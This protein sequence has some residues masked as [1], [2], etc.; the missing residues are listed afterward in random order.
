MAVVDIGVQDNATGTLRRIRRAFRSTD[1]AIQETNRSTK[2]LSSSLL[3]M[4]GGLATAYLGIQTLKSIGSLGASFVT[5][6]ST[7]EGFETTLRSITGSS[8]EAKK[9]MEWIQEFGAKTPYEIDKVT[10]SFVKMKAYGLDPMD[11]TLTALG[12]ASSAMG[13]DI[14]QAVEA[15]ADAVTGENER[16]KE[17]G[18]K[19]SKTG[20]TIKY[21]WADSSG[22]MRD[23]VVKN[24][25]DIIQSTL[26]AIFNEKYVGAMDAQSATWAGMMSNSSDA[27]T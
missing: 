24:N 2:T 11:G 22:K 3:R 5:T 6:A 19:A 18:I 10:E 4:A 20:E 27:W 17:F 9:S 13:K 12:N 1:D 15:M 14:T 26:T 21:A 23:V 16:L 25:K 8:I 7:F